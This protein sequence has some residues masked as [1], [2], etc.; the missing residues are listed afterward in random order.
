[1]RILMT[2]LMLA[3]AAMIGGLI[4]AFTV[5]PPVPRSTHKNWPAQRQE[6]ETATGGVIYLPTGEHCC[7]Y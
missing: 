4:L 5:L 3:M 7:D 2:V 6:S 1:M